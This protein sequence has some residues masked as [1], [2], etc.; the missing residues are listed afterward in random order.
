MEGLKEK[1]E[2]KEKWMKLTQEMQRQRV[3]E[4]ESSYFER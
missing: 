2:T 4:F 3:A 1:G